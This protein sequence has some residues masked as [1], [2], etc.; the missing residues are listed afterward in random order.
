ML[1]MRAGVL[2]SQNKSSTNLHLDRNGTGRLPHYMPTSMNSQIGVTAFPSPKFTLNEKKKLFENYDTTKSL[3]HHTRQ[4]NPDPMKKISNQIAPERKNLMLQQRTPKISRQIHRNQH[5]SHEK[6]PSKLK[7]TR[8][9]FLDAKLEP[10]KIP[11]TNLSER[12]KAS[13]SIYSRQDRYFCCNRIDIRSLIR[14]LFYQGH[15]VESLEEFRSPAFKKIQN[16]QDFFDILSQESIILINTVQKSIE[17]LLTKWIPPNDDPHPTASKYLP[18]IKCPK[19]YDRVTEA[20]YNQLKQMEQI[21][22]EIEKLMRYFIEY[23]IDLGTESEGF[24]MPQRKL[25]IQVFNS[26]EIKD[27]FEQQ[28]NNFK[29]NQI[30]L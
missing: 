13:M 26:D 12:T 22:A 1:I 7:I 14:C 9:W 28:Y 2:T 18:L 24:L 25:L 19:K 15:T 4:L 30:Y 3:R 6:M 11:L 16:H 23:L 20:I 5:R 21:N 8:Q 10:V 29:D 17:G 27:F